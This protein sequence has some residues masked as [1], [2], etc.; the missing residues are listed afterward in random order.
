MIPRFLI[1]GAAWA[2]LMGL[3]TALPTPACPA[4]E[5]LFATFSICAI[6]P[7]TGE[8]GAAVTTRVPFVGRAVP[9]VEAGVGAAATQS[10]TV[11]EYGRRGLDLLKDGVPPAEYGLSA[12]TKSASAVRT[13]IG[14]SG[15]KASF[16]VET[17]SKDM[18]FSP[19]NDY[20]NNEEKRLSGDVKLNLMDNLTLFGDYLTYDNMHNFNTTD[21][22]DYDRIG[23]GATF[24][25]G[26]IKEITLKKT[27]F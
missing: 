21:K 23:A 6:D 27:R 15:K 2:A 8:S 20:S 1:L 9:W 14:Y 16:N 24:R 13:K 22:D 5:T 11:V 12:T 4:D 3:C 18:A 26:R 25:K 17:I 10:W 19:L 7:I